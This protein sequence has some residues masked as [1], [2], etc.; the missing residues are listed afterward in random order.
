V[1]LHPILEILRQRR[2]CDYRLRAPRLRL[3]FP[4]FDSGQSRALR[5]LP[6]REAAKILIAEDKPPCAASQRIDVF[7]DAAALGLVLGDCITQGR[8]RGSLGGETGF[9]NLVPVSGGI[10]AGGEQ[11]APARTGF[12]VFA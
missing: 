8:L 11:V 4:P 2:F 5:S 10:F 6:A 3:G 7:R 9:E 1:L 12:S